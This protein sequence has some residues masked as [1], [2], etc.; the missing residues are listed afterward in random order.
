L[1]SRVTNMV[2]A[3]EKRVDDITPH[4]LDD[5]LGREEYQ[6][7]DFKEALG[8]TPNFEIA[9][10][11]GSFANAGGGLIVIG[12]IEDPKTTACTGFKPVIGTE[13]VRKKIEQIALDRIQNRLSV[14]PR[15]TKTKN[16][17]DIILVAI[18]AVEALV[19]VV[20]DQGQPEYWQRVGRN[21]R[22]MTHAE[23]MAAAA[24]RQ[25]DDG[26]EANVW[27]ARWVAKHRAVA[28]D[29]LIRATGSEYFFEAY[30][31]FSQHRTLALPQATLYQAA[32]ASFS[33]T[34]GY[35]PIGFMGA[36]KA[37]PQPRADE[38]VLE[39]PD[40]GTIGFG[41]GIPYTYWALNQ[42]AQFYLLESY[43]EDLDFK[44]GNPT[45]SRFL[46]L[47]YRVAQATDLVL[48]ASRLFRALLASRTAGIASPAI[49]RFH[50]YYHGLLGRLLGIAG[51]GWTFIPP[52]SPVDVDEVS[53]AITETTELLDR[54]LTERL[55]WLAQGLT[56][57][58][59]GLFGFFELKPEEYTRL[60][61]HWRGLL[62]NQTR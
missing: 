31:D 57:T 37:A 38:I 9:K 53:C 46:F 26:D 6:R 19:A 18:P 41:A 59:F 40:A 54:D 44:R 36:G 11:L 39:I 43:L 5:L 7:L 14:S 32:R 55:P 12:A 42:R 17:E 60:T 61:L 23:V 52:H 49:A 21:K 8:T 62:E 3:E 58:L 27:T 15:V 25:Q 28:R 51:S 24:A 2:K 48:Y 34:P 20:N 30:F 56:A 22:R 47:D 16:G 10:D 50:M 45:N 1:P 13:S 4:D 35:W 33:R 29:G